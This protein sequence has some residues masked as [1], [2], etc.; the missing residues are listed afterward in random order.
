MGCPYSDK[1][2]SGL[3]PSQIV[4][5]VYDQLPEPFQQKFR[6][7]YGDVEKIDGSEAARAYAHCKR[8]LKMKRSIRKANTQLTT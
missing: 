7:Q 8:V 2:R 4:K 6:V 3:L 1:L 5:E